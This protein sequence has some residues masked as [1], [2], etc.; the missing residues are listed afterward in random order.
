MGHIWKDLPIQGKIGT[1]IAGILLLLSTVAMLAI[2]GLSQ[3]VTDSQ[4]VA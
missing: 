1:G 3:V 2:S 4:E